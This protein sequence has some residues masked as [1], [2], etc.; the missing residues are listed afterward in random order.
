MMCTIC[1]QPVSRTSLTVNT[2]QA[3]TAHL[4]ADCTAA[5]MI[6][7]R[8]FIEGEFLAGEPG[9]PSIDSIN[10]AT[11]QVWA[12]LPDSSALLVERAVE[13]AQRAFPAWAAIGPEARGK[14]L[15]RLADLIGRIH[16]H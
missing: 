13:A 11:G 12:T 4:V 14:L 7:V 10:P 16:K 1:R 3:H 15:L 8:N 6:T 2:D 5:V 9:Q